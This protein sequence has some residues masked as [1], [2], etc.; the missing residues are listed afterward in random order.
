MAGDV[1]RRNTGRSARESVIIAPHFVGGEFSLWVRIE[2]CPVAI[3]REHDEQFRV[4]ARGR[5]ARGRKLLDC[6]IEN[7][8]KLHL[9]ISPRRHGDTEKN[10]LEVIEEK[11][12]S[13]RVDHNC[14]ERWQLPNFARPGRAR[15]PS[16][17]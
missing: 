3:E 17:H 2:I 15:R 10:K 11:C 1:L 9:S 14:R 4:H 5:D 6:R 7:L 12:H 13:S 8:A 16:P